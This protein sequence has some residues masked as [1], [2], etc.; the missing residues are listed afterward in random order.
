MELRSRR[1][2][3]RLGV[4][5]ADALEPGDLVT[6]TG[7]LGAG[8]TFLA[9][10]IARQLG[11]PREI[12]I[13]SPTFTLVQE[14][15][16]KKG[17]L[18]HVDLYR[19]RDTANAVAD[20]RRLGLAERRAEGAILLVEWAHGFER[21]LGGDVSLAIALEIEGDHRKATITGDRIVDAGG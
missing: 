1:D 14:Y 5:I 9:R 10:A 11:V 20:V 21:E 3:T 18:L 16:T 2:T 13:A 12:A 6:L 17:T 4:R 19:L 15:E 7:D 8:K